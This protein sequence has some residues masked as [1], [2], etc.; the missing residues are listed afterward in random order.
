MV[1]DFHCLAAEVF[2]HKVCQMKYNGQVIELEQSEAEMI[3][4]SRAARVRKL[5]YHVVQLRTFVW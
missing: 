5:Q 3:T 4:S 1:S 2:N